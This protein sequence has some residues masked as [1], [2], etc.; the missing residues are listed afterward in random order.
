MK[1]VEV[2]AKVPA[3][4]K[5][6]TKELGPVA[7]A[8]NYAETLDE[9]KE[10]FGDEAILSNAFANWKVTLQSA[11]RTGLKQ[12]LSQAEI[13]AKLGE[14]K[15]G[16]ALRTS[17]KVDPETAWLAKYQSATPAERKKM[18]QDLERKAAALD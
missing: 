10:M 4:E 15:M 17:R 5:K 14:A 2:S 3:N 11:I 8:V 7:I 9:G 16:T 13:Q 12:G 6:G 18:R 1:Q